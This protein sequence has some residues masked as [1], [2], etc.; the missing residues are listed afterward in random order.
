MRGACTFVYLVGTCREEGIGGDGRMHSNRST[1][2]MRTSSHIC[3][4]DFYCLSFAVYLASPQPCVLYL[5]VRKLL[6]QST[7]A[8][9]TTK[10]M[11]QQ[12]MWPPS[13]VRRCNE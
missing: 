3:T 13:S 1:N 7:K 6:L 8:A 9:A 11:Q 5:S 12:H 4:Y 2:R 10:A